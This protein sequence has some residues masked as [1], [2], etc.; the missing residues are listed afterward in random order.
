MKRKSMVFDSGVVIE[1]LSGSE[2]GKKI[3]GFIEEGLDEVFINELNME[4]IKYV[5]CRRSG[6]EKAEGL[7]GLLTSTGYFTVLPFSRVKG[8]VYK[9]KCKYPI[10]LADATSIASGK[11]LGIPS[12]F[13]REKEIEPFKEELGILFVDEL[14]R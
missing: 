11:A 10:S 12:L 9:I 14:L 6:A 2:E 7:E 3:E 5:V 1:L 8:E 4:E 13:K